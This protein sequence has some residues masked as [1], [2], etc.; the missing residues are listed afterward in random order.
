MITSS[1]P[2]KQRLREEIEG[3]RDRRSGVGNARMI[4]PLTLIMAAYLI[5]ELCERIF[6]Y[7]R[8]VDI[9]VDV[10]VIY[11]SVRDFE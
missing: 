11:Q 4:P 9:L 8:G 1:R 7:R 10:L 2:L 6:A 3:P 5:Q